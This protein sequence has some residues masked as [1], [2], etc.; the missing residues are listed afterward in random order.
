MSDELE[1]PFL[2]DGS[3]YGISESRFIELEPSDQKELMLQWFF[4]NF[5]DPANQ[6][7]WDGEDKEYVYIFGG[8]YN[9]EEEIQSKFA[10]L[11]PDSLIAEV[12]EEIQ[13]DGTVDWAPNP[14]SSYYDDGRDSE[15]ETPDEPPPL[16]AYL[17]ERSGHYGSAEELE[18]RA[19]AIA[20]LEHLRRVAQRHR[21]IGIG[22]NRPPGEFQIL[23]ELSQ[24]PQALI[25]L[26]TELQKP[27]PEISRVKHW[28]TPL[29]DALLA[30]TKWTVKK[31]DGA[32][33]AVINLGAA[34]GSVLL[35]EH[36]EYLRI[37]YNA[38]VHWLDIAAKS[39]F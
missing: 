29:R 19:N 38:V 30:V 39:L 13:A 2:E 27:A 23:S 14:N 32:V 16:D 25:E 35:V 31:I 26:S 11:V 9:A 1:R 22:H 20:A 34:G 12:A 36:P 28:A 17:D 8:P 5:E 6:T 24:L 21:H 33:T 3:Q 37:A 18:A 15:A 7:P 4:Q 10:G